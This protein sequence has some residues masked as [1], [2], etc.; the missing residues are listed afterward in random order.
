MVAS[1]VEQAVALIEGGVD[2]LLIETA[3]DLGQAKATIVAAFEA[4]QKAG[5][6]LPVTVQVTLQERTRLGSHPRPVPSEISRVA[7]FVWLSGVS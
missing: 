6:R 3:Q 7:L 2:V 5:K 1:Y 4:M